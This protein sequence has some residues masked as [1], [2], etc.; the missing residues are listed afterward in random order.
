MERADDE[1]TRLRGGERGLHG[2]PVAHLADDDDVRVLP[3]RLLHAVGKR[4]YVGTDLAL[5]DDA[6]GGAEPELDR[7]LDGNDHA[8]TGAADALDHRGQR[9]GRAGA[10]DAGDEDEPLLALAELRHGGAVTQRLELG[11]LFRDVTE[12]RFQ[13]ATRVMGIGAKTAQPGHVEC[14]VEP[15][16][17]LATRPLCLGQLAEDEVITNVRG[18]RCAGQSDNFAVDARQRRRG[19]VEVKIR[20]LAPDRLREESDEIGGLGVAHEKVAGCPPE[21]ETLPDGRW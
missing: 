14:E 11:D 16:F 1:V 21:E 15:L 5:L 7:V 3:E 20:G 18:E 6:H 9:R 8:R 13:R 2:L 12:D 19:A 10:G 4:L 17:R